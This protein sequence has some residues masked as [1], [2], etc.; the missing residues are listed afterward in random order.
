MDSHLGWQ[1]AILHS[2]VQQSLQQASAMSQEM[3]PGKVTAIAA[4]GF[5]G[6]MS[7]FAMS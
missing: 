5:V 3:F 7:L 1:L 4:S 6:R 2:L